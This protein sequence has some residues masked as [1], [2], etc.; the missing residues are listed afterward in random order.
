VRR[1]RHDDTELPAG[2]CRCIA[3]A[4]DRAS[5][6]LHEPRL[7][8]DQHAVRVAQLLDDVAADVV[9]D[10][11]GIPHGVAGPFRQRPASL[12]LHIGQEALDESPDGL[13]RLHA[14]RPAMRS[15]PASSRPGSVYAAARGHRTIFGWFTNHR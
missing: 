7:V 11:V 5:T 6:L 3:A 15:I 10:R 4:P 14:D 8:G 2:G 13:S 9:A 12:T 1:D